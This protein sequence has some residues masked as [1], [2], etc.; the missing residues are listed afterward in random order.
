M[1]QDTIRMDKLNKLFVQ[2]HAKVTVDFETSKVLIYDGHNL[3][4][5]GNSIRE[6]VD[7]IIKK[8]LEKA[9]ET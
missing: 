4:G 2:N 8:D 1:L 5:R 7:G 6:A 9:N 3:L